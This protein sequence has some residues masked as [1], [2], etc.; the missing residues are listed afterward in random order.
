MLRDLR[1]RGESGLGEWFGR[2]WFEQPTPASPEQLR[3]Y[4]PWIDTEYCSL[5]APDRYGERIETL[6]DRVAQALSRIIKD[7]DAEF[8]AQ[9]RG[10]EM[11]T[12][13]ICGHAAQIVCSGRVLTG[14][15]PD[16]PNEED[17]RCYTCGISKFVRKSVA[18][19]SGMRNDDEWRSNGGVA[20]GWDC[21]LNSDCKHL[22]QGEERGWHFHGD[23]SFDSYIVA[24]KQSALRRADG[25]Q[26]SS[27]K[28]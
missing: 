6:H 22:S 23:E 12:L 3:G 13:L 16:D 4:F 8:E 25:N 11:V 10:S 17:F 27:S 5:L 9:G 14:M 28:L 20:G 19:D 21:V 1:V 2:A 7:V 15:M 18:I 26:A 24:A